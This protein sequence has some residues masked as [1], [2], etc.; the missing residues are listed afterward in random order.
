MNAKPLDD[1]PPP[2]VLGRPVAMQANMPVYES[3]TLFGTARSLI[4]R[5]AGEEYR[6]MI[7]RQNKLILT[8]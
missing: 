7:T 2:S 8:K 3:G 1:Q 4:I 6:L 5:H